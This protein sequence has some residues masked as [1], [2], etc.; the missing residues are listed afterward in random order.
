MIPILGRD[1]LSVGEPGKEVPL[2]AHLARKLADDLHVSAED[3]PAGRELSE[4]A[5]RFV[6]GDE[7][8]DIEDVYAALHRL[9][10]PREELEPPPALLK[11]AEISAFKLF[12][13]T[14]F[15]P[16]LELAIDRVHYGGKPKTQVLSYSPQNAADLPSE[17][18]KLEVKTVFHLLGRLS[19]V[20]DYAVTDEDLLEFVHALQSRTKRPEMLFDE[21]GRQRLLIIGSGF[22]NWLARFFLR[23][24]SGE[25]LSVAGGKSF[26]ADAM[27]SGD[28]NLRGF[29]Q[30]FCSRTQI[31]DGSGPV[32]FVEELHARWTE[33]HPPGAA[34]EQPAEDGTDQGAIKIERGAVFLSYASEDREKILIIRGA[35]E[36]VGVDVWFDKEA[37]QSGDNFAEVISAYI[38]RCSL[39]LP[40]LSRSTLTGERR[41]F[42]QEWSQADRL[43]D[44]VAPNEKFIIPIAID[45]TPPE[46]DAIP[47]R[48]RDLDWEFAPDGIVSPKFVATVQK[49]VRRFHKIQAG[50]A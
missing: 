12:V 30:Q 5:A 6:N 39:F 9:M 16:L 47:R 44:R 3:L 43:A 10:P 46:H 27:V 23:A 1:L 37:L 26:V 31:F 20:P 48:F 25:R 11:L 40:V 14:T 22:P 33:R 7:R 28:D 29:L 42:R 38:E 35:L 4:V 36:K 19:V 50:G 17:L 41:F 32:E 21:F 45:D 18:G 34:V 49:L 24:T 13:T 2:Y 8:G 15:D